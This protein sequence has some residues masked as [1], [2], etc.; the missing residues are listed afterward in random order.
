MFDDFAEHFEGP[1]KVFNRTYYDQL[2]QCLAKDDDTLSYQSQKGVWKGI[3][4]YWNT[5]GTDSDYMNK[6][7]HW[8]ECIGSNDPRCLWSEYV[9]YN[10]SK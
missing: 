10:Q 8:G 6:T 3:V 5:N 2:L 9:E 4:D 1:G 7:D